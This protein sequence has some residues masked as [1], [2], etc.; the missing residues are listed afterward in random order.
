MNGK[1]GSF[2]HLTLGQK[3]PLS[4]LLLVSDLFK[5]TS[6]KW[7]VCGLAQ[8][9]D[10]QFVYVRTNTSAQFGGRRF[11]EGHHQQLF[12]AERTPKRSIAAQ[13]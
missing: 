11:G 8:A 2:V 10:T 1:D 7:V 6:V 13:S 5:K 4:G 12:H 3:Q 9:G